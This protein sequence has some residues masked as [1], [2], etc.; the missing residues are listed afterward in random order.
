MPS[1]PKQELWVALAG[2]AVNVV[3]AAVLYLGL[4]ADGGIRSNALSAVEVA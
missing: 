2:P 1:D 4:Y 3:I